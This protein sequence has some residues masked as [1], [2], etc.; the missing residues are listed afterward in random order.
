MRKARPRDASMFRSIGC[1]GKIEREDALAARE[2][3]VD[4]PDGALATCPLDDPSLPRRLGAD[5][6]GPTS[7]RI[8][9]ESELAGSD[10]W[11]SVR[12]AV[13]LGGARGAS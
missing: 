13:A 10:R 4:A 12:S 8:S 2:P 9:I 11:R 5:E 7:R 6:V 1:Y 3:T